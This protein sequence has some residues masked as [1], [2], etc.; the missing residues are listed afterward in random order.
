MKISKQEKEEII[1]NFEV[2]TLLKN[3]R[4]LKGQVLLNEFLNTVV[5]Y[6]DTTP[7][8]KETID[9]VIECKKALSDPSKYNPP[10]LKAEVLQILNIAPSSEVEVHLIVE[11]CEDRYEPYIPSDILSDIKGTLKDAVVRDKELL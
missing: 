7:A 11:D 5:R 3:K 8:A 6:L 9:T 1:T 2:L 4:R 10:I